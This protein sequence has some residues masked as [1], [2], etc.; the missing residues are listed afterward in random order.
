MADEV[1]ALLSDCR[2]AVLA[3]VCVR[4]WFLFGRLCLSGDECVNLIVVVPTEAALHRTTTADRVH[5][6]TR[7]LLWRTM[8]RARGE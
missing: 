1:V 6:T 3:N 8:T 5:S 7:L 4:L 2:P